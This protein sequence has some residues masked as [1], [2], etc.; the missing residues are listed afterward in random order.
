MKTVPAVGCF[1]ATYP[2]GAGGTLAPA[3]AGTNA[4]E[5]VPYFTAV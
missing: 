5:S 4:T 3:T 2:V 1:T